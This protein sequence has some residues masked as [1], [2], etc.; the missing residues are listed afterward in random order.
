MNNKVGITKASSVR[1]VVKHAGAGGLELDSLAGQIEHSVANGS[2][3]LRWFFGTVLLRLGAAEMD[4]TTRCT[5][6]LNTTSA[7]KS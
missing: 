3:P 6:R 5:L 4:P 1:S 2:A 7:M